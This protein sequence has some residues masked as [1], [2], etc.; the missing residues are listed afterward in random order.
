MSIA[1]LVEDQLVTDRPDFGPGDT[2]RVHTRITEGDKQRIQIFEG[3]ILKRS[4]GTGL[5]GNFTVRR[6]ASGI[7]VERTFLL[8]SPNVQS[9]EVIRRGK[10]RR[11]RLYYLR[12]IKSRSIKI[13]EKRPAQSA[14]AKEATPE[15]KPAKEAAAPVEAPETT[16]AEA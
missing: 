14:K 12:D 2:V 9:I 7:G 13:K 1:H 15:A 6:I 4:K 5:S 8:H 16:T 11:A 10:V 3:I